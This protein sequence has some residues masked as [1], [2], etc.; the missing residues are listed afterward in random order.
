MSTTIG[1]EIFMEQNLLQFCGFAWNH[2]S[3]NQKILTTMQGTH[4]ACNKCGLLLKC[5]LLS[6]FVCFYN[7]NVSYFI[8]VEKVHKLPERTGPSLQK[9]CHLATVT[10]Y[11]TTA[12]A[13]GSWQLSSSVWH[14]SSSSMVTSHISSYPR[15]IGSTQNL[16]DIITALCTCNV[17]VFMHTPRS[18][19]GL[20]SSNCEKDSRN[21]CQL[22]L[23]LEACMCATCL[24][25]FCISLLFAWSTA[26]ENT[27][28]HQT[29]SHTWTRTRIHTHSL[30]HTPTPTEPINK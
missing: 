3:F 22:T 23:V 11:F 4:F 6:V 2:E 29:H 16:L 15:T 30:T 17:G 8:I 14:G 27:L 20:D 5:Q 13:K 24:T 1:R 21:L 12:A 7:G 9:Y 26:L 19:L 28:T 18:E 25:V 10:S